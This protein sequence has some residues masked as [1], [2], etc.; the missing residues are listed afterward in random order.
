LSWNRS[1]GALALLVALAS[2]AAPVSATDAERE[3]TRATMRQIFESI[4]V[5]LPLSVN[6]EKF[7]APENRAAIEQALAALA[8]N[9]GALLRMRAAPIPR[10]ATSAIVEHDA[11]RRSIATAGHR[12]AAFRIRRPPR[13]ASRV[14]P[15]C[16]PAASPA[17][18]HFVDRSARRPAARRT[19]SLEVAT[20]HFD[21]AA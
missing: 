19:R 1:A 11:R 3:A 9:A 16:S 12:G 14:M 20:R 8:D 4:R 2:H 7:A 15:S 13:T 18:E 21:E 10:A 17:A 6:E 5:V